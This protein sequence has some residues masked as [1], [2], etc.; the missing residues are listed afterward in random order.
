MEEIQTHAGPYAPPILLMCDRAAD[1]GRRAGAGAAGRATGIVKTVQTRE[2]LLDESVLLLHRAEADLAPD[3]C[4]ILE[5]LRETDVTLF[6]KKV[7]V[8]DDDV[9][10]IFALT[11]LLEDHNLKVAARRKWP[12]RHRTVEE[13][14]GHRS[15]ADGHHDAGDGR[16]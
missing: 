12:G 13:D 3:Q 6:G 2:R 1:A 10:N 16:L 11:S 4:R 5:Q 7:L 15:G 14:A 8:V 9:R